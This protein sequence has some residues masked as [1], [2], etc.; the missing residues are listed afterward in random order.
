MDGQPSSVMDGQPSSVKDG[1][2]SYV[3]DGQPSSVNDGQQSSVRD[4]QPSS[5]KDGQSSRNSRHKYV[6]CLFRLYSLS[7]TPP[8]F[9]RFSSHNQLGNNLRSR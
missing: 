6:K 3:M 4:G 9:F 7:P 5:V 8:R 2:P 1:Q